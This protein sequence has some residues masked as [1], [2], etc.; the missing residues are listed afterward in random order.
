MCSKICIYLAPISNLL[1]KS[2]MRLA[3]GAPR[4]GRLP[5]IN[6]NMPASRLLAC[7]YIH[8]DMRQVLNR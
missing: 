5:H 2:S 1:R 7:K 4:L 3:R 6:M 8:V